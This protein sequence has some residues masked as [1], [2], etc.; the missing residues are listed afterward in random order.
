MT[1]MQKIHFRDL[2]TMAYAEAWALQE[3]SF[4]AIIDKKVR[5]R[6]LPP[7]KQEP[8]GQFIYFVEHPPVITLGKNADVHNVISDTHNLSAAH[9]EVYPVNRGGDVTFHGPGQLVVYP[10]L[11]L[12]FFFTD[13][14]KY[15][16][17]LEEVIIRTLDTYGIRGDRLPGATGVWLE[18]D[19]ATARK[20]CAI[21]IRCSRW[22]TMHGLAFNVN[23]DLRYFDH[24]IPCGISGK[25]VTSLT[26]ELQRTA[27][28]ED[29]KQ[30]VRTQ[31]AEV[32][33]CHLQ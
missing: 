22:V 5:N 24:I 1:Y 16:R 14:G 10:V 26:H 19:K 30:R 7:G 31:F 27:D 32:F 23:T 20:I 29:V 28:M 18:P 6:N 4:A 15:L 25:A 3:E 8:Y 17:S 33:H 12:D 21:G 11:D 9:I 13:I 2:G